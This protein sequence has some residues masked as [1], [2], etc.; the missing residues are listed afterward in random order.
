MNPETL[1]L[2]ELAPNSEPPPEGFFELPA[3]LQPSARRLVKW[4]Y[5]LLRHRRW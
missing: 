5:S 2:A 3:K 4:E 1:Q